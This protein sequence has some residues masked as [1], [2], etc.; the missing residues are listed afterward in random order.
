M[1]HLYF[2]DNSGQNRYTFRMPQNY[3]GLDAKELV[4]LINPIVSPFPE[5]ELLRA[6]SQRVKDS[7]Q[8]KIVYESS[9]KFREDIDHIPELG[10]EL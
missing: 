4:K 5:L 1:S 6:D 9:S 3:F 8:M 10:P 7:P 2:Q